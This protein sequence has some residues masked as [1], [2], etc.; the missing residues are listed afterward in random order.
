[1]RTCVRG[2]TGLA[3]RA[4]RA[5][6]ANVERD[7]GSAAAAELPRVGL[8]DALRICLVLVRAEPG[9]YGRAAVRWLGRLLLDE[10][11]ALTLN[12]PRLVASALAA[13]PRWTDDERVLIA[14]RTFGALRGLA[15]SAGTLDELL[16]R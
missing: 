11:P 3:S 16:T 4:L 8:D 13:L 1:M 12:E 14:S 5:G 7:L 15:R 2:A 10:R 9:R 6:A